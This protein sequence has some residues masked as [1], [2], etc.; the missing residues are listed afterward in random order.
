MFGE[1]TEEQRRAAWAE[2]MAEAETLAAGIR[3]LSDQYP[4]DEDA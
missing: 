1:N 4:P 3:D 2:V